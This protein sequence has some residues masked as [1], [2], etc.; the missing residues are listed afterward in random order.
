MDKST[1]PAPARRD[2]GATTALNYV[3]L[4]VIV[5]LLVTGLLVGV[6]GL[7]ENQ[8][9]RAVR[10]QLETVGTRLAADVGT[11]NRLVERPGGDT[12]QL[13]TD[14]PDGVGGAEYRIDVENA[15]GD[16]YRLVVVSPTTEVR[17]VTTVRSAVPVTGGAA[18]GRVVV[19]YDSTADEL[20]IRDA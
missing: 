1:R 6:S 3:L 15:G 5:A 14:L 7:V 10:S 4:L 20:V 13:R 16:R 12:V 18:G 8:R 17:T 11:A 9:E 19:E 2:R